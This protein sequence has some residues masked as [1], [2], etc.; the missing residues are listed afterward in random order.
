[1]TTKPHDR[2]AK[3]FLQE[4]LSPLGEVS[5]GNEVTDE[6]RFVD[7]LFSPTPTSITQAQTLG[8]LGKVAT[9][10][11]ALLEPYRN[12]PSRPQIRNC[13]AK[14]FILIADA[15]REAQDNSQFAI[16][17]SQLSLNK[18]MADSMANI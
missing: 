5:V 12:Q 7:V 9:Q 13:I 17:N 3:Q 14:V 16:R 4:L 10:N 15:E 1:M 8:L 18:N 6:A 2:F 11:T